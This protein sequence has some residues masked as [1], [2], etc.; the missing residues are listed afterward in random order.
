MSNVF[1]DN[2]ES[3]STI[4]TLAPDALHVWYLELNGDYHYR[5]SFSICSVAEQARAA[6]FKAASAQVN[7]LHIRTQ[8][9]RILG[10]YLNVAPQYVTFNYGPQGKPQISWP[11]A[12][13]KFNLSHSSDLCLIAIN[14]NTEIGIDVELV[15]SRSNLLAIAQRMFN[16]EVVAELTALSE[17]TRLQRFYFY[18]TNFEAQ[19]KAYGDGLFTHQQLFIPNFKSFNNTAAIN[20]I[21]FI[22]A[23][24]FQACIAALGTLPSQDQW[25]RFKFVNEILG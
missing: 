1:L 19:T 23:L 8:L 12:N 16:P 3:V 9:R 21:N 18:W 17:A 6:S 2:W 22:P 4:P 20:S 11:Q 7:F 10:S 13:L 5:E 25:H 24:G 15:R 14:W